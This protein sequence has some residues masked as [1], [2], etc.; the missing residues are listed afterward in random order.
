MK[1]TK[2][3]RFINGTKGVISLFLACLLVPFTTLACALLTAARINSAVAIFDEALC[4]ASNSTLGTYDSFLR[5]R[6]GLLAMEQNTSGKAAI[7]GN[8]YSVDDL[9]NDTFN[10][11]LKE[12][13][14]TLSNTYITSQAEAKGVYSL[15]DTDVLLAQILE[16][17]KYSVPTKMLTDGLDLDD[18]ARYVDSFFESGFAITDFISSLLGSFGSIITLC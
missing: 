3:Y 13:L 2:Q 8:P 16:Y 15:A 7:G 14:K 5:K 18:L 10:E 1:K 4:N 11:F 17:S 6:F 9:I 12:N